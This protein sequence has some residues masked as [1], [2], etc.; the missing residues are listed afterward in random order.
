VEKIS[1]FDWGGTNHNR[2]YRGI[3]PHQN[4]STVKAIPFDEPFG[5]FSKPTLHLANSSHHH[6]RLR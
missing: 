1:I 5:F 6:E 2:G 4:S 3:N